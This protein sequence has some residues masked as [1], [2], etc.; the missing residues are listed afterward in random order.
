MAD[1]TQDELLL[2]AS[3]LLQLDYE[4][5]AAQAVAESLPP[6]KTAGYARNR[7]EHLEHC[8]NQIQRIARLHAK[9]LGR[10]V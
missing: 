2:I 3:G 5:R 10:S 6:A 9:V 1:F 7:R 4:Y 8:E